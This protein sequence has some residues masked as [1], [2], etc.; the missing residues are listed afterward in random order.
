MAKDAGR[1]GSWG[2]EQA[3]C[4]G[5][6]QAGRSRNCVLGFCGRSAPRGPVRRLGWSVISLFGHR[7]ELLTQR[8]RKTGD[9]HVGHH[10]LGRHRV[11][12]GPPSGSRRPGRAGRSAGAGVRRSGRFARSDRAHLEGPRGGPARGFPRPRG[13]CLH[14]AGAGGTGRVFL[15]RPMLGPIW[16]LGLPV[17]TS[18]ASGL[19]A[20][21]GFASG[22]E[23][24][25]S[26]PWGPPC[27]EPALRP[28]GKRCWGDCAPR[29]SRAW[30]PP[31]TRWTRPR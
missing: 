29:R 1:G 25:R 28:G 7:T 11:G 9:D 26:S 24:N 2:V 13:L 27:P 19:V 14:D 22:P 17:A 31:L 20:L 6:P 18:P 23:M 21:I 12:V 3:D 8:H 4:A 30:W 5:K 15:W 16:W 10:G